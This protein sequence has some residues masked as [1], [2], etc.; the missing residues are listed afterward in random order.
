MLPTRELPSEGRA[1]EILTAELARTTA[2]DLTRRGYEQLDLA[3]LEQRGHVLADP[4]TGKLWQHDPGE[5]SAGRS[6]E[7]YAFGLTDSLSPRWYRRPERGPKT[8]EEFDRREQRRREERERQESDRALDIASLRLRAEVVTLSDVTGLPDVSLRRAVEE[9]LA[10]GGVVQ[11][12]SGR[13]VIALPKKRKGKT[14]FGPK[15]ATLLARI[16]YL[17]SEEIL[18]VS[19]RSGDVDPEQIPDKVVLPSGRVA[20]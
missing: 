19:K 6:V 20:P 13:V 5:P 16:V 3:R 10:L 1:R 8:V 17:A 11:V 2:D 15:R 4:E 14:Q 7:H 18:A 12:R 9:L